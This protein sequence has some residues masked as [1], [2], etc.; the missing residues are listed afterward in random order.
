MII[1]F[2]GNEGSVLKLDR[3]HFLRPNQTKHITSINA[4]GSFHIRLSEYIYIISIFL[5]QGVPL[6]IEI[7]PRDV[8]SGSVVISRRDIP[9][10]QGKVFG[11]SMEPSILEAYVKDKLDEIQSSLLER[12]IAFRDRSV[13]F[14]DT[15]CL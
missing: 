10:K 14:S 1:Q 4:A 2:L 13:P 15:F 8:S 9:G 5:F 11:I 6:R 3:I 7:G 12:A